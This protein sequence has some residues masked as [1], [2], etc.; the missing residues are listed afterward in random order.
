MSGTLVL[1]L[2]R[3]GFFSR[4]EVALKILE[5]VGDTPRAKKKANRGG[6]WFY[7]ANPSHSIISPGTDI[8][9]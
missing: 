3:L 1:E 8:K 4:K 6:W 9:L 2:Y 5:I 7:M